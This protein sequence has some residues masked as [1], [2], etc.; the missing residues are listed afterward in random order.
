M[1][2]V[3]SMVNTYETPNHVGYKPNIVNSS[4]KCLP[5]L[6]PVTLA[7]TSLQQERDG[8][9]NSLVLSL[10]PWVS[11]T[12]SAALQAGSSVPKGLFPNGHFLGPRPHLQ[13][14]HRQLSLNYQIFKTGTLI[15][16][17]LIPLP[18]QPQHKL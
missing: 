5:P 3:D 11:L 16:H 14:L 7:T 4:L 17:T 2:R 12:M 8:Q 18:Q 13:F 9:I 1:M 15:F 10:G 6:Q